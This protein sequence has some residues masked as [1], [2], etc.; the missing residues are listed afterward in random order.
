MRLSQAL[1]EAKLF[2]PRTASRLL[3]MSPLPPAHTLLPQRLESRQDK[4]EG[5]LLGGLADSKSGPERSLFSSMLPDSGAS[6]LPNTLRLSADRKT[7]I[8]GEDCA[9]RCQ[10][11]FVLS[12]ILGADLGAPERAGIP[13]LREGGT[14]RRGRDGPG[15]ALGD[16]GRQLD[17][18]LMM[19]LEGEEGETEAAAWPW[20]RGG[21]S[22]PGAFG[23]RVFVSWLREGHSEEHTSAF[24]ALGK[25]CDNECGST[26]Y[27]VQSARNLALHS[28]TVCGTQYVLARIPRGA[29]GI[30]DTLVVQRRRA[31][32]F[33]GPGLRVVRYEGNGTE[34]ERGLQCIMT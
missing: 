19:V 30:H 17:G 12:D 13:G 4:A 22:L 23:M 32:C 8:G 2:T 1:T 11:G 18:G 16:S 34:G 14:R 7:P 6:L 28:A 20:L 24:C 25:C 33:S 9:A 21:S 15:S 27:D 29:S 5:L 10:D 26:H 31:G 3:V